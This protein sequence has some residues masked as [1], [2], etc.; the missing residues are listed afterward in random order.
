[1]KLI[2]PT[3]FEPLDAIWVH[4]ARDKREKSQEGPKL[5]PLANSA[6]KLAAPVFAGLPR[7]PNETVLHH[8]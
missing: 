1:M 6:P 3:Y 4:N 2:L 8:S 7:R 5:N